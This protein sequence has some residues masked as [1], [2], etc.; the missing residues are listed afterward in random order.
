M[1]NFSTI[2]T[3][4]KQNERVSDLCV[5]TF[6]RESPA[7]WIPHIWRDPKCGESN[8]RKLLPKSKLTRKAA[9]PRAADFDFQRGLLSRNRNPLDQAASTFAV[10]F[11][12]QI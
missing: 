1:L 9:C 3:V 11:G 7:L 4:G 5:V 2:V 8:Q 6:F 12:T 10:D